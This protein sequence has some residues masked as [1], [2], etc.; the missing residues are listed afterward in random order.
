MVPR[1]SL[2]MAGGKWSRY[3]PGGIFAMTK[4]NNETRKQ[5]LTAS[6]LDNVTG[7]DTKAATTGATK[8]TSKTPQ[9]YMV[10]TMSD[11]LISSY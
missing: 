5:E 11:A 6:E 10:Y 2:I 3:A 7:G 8:T 1:I 4:R 9:T